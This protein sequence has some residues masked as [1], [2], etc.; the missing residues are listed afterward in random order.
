MSEPGSLDPINSLRA[1]NPAHAADVPDASLA[2]VSATVTEHIMTHDQKLVSP[3][4]RRRWTFALLGGAAIT[5]VLVL[6]V[7]SSAGFFGQAPSGNHGNGNGIPPGGGLSSCI[8]YDPALLPTFEVVFDGTVTAIDGD[9][10]TFQVNQGWKA[11]SGSITL[12]AADAGAV[13]LVGPGPDFA[14]GSRYLVTAAGGNVNGCGFTLEYDA[15][16]AASWAAAFSN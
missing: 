11:A 10:V 13:S 2:R 8:P 15:A 14:I 16:E 5:G 3:P 7:A 12:T 4:S 1:A 6:A 9:Q